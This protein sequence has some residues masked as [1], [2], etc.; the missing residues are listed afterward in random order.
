MTQ[1]QRE[2][3]GE[4][5]KREVRMSVHIQS[6]YPKCLS[7]SKNLGTYTKCLSTSK[8]LCVSEMSVHI[9]IRVRA[10]IRVQRQYPF[11]GLSPA[12]IV[13]LP[14]ARR[15]APTRSKERTQTRWSR[16]TKPGPPLLPCRT[17][18]S[19]H[20]GTAH[21]PPAPTPD[22]ASIDAPKRIC[23]QRKHPPTP[24]RPLQKRNHN[25]E[26]ER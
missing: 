3:E 23:D 12:P 19:I 10:Q 17:Q 25:Q 8:S 16:I 22:Y 13:P 20:S 18:R 21:H 6:P 24:R 1:K 2:N 5:K 15:Q 7:T 26:L 14:P 4:E 9:Y 11:A